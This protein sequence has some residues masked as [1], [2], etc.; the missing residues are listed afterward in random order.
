MARMV[1]VLE[2]V[3]RNERGGYRAEDT[4]AITQSEPEVLGHW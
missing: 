3:I 1:F 2:P 4:D